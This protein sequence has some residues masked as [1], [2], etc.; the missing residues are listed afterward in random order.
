MFKDYLKKMYINAAL[1]NDRNVLKA[2]EE[3]GP[4]NTLLDVGCWDGLKTM[5]ISAAAKTKKIFGIEPILNAAKVAENNGIKTYQI[6][7]DQDQWPIKANSI[8]CIVSNQVVEHLT[9]LDNYFSQASQVLKKGGLLITSTNN[10][11][12]WHNI[13]A[14]IFGFAPFD[15]TNSSSKERGIGNPF[16]VHRNEQDERGGSWTHKCIYTAKWLMDWQTLYN[17]KT[18]KTY[19]AG[20]YPLPSKI[21]NIFPL[22]SAFITL[23]AQK[24]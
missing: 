6:F 21:G 3:S 23:V 20:Y 11:S 8:D 1:L 16:A 9:N 10:L 12:S 15:L 19:G 22:H 17:L 4:H 14:L 7:A 18:I 2:V 5:E 24:Q 13:G